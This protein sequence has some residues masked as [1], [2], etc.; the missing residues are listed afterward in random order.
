M[1]L[2]TTRQEATAHLVQNHARKLKLIEDLLCVI[3]AC[4]DAYE[5]VSDSSAYARICG[6]TLLKG[7]NLGLGALSLSLDGLAQEAGALIRPFIEYVELLTYFR[8]FPEMVERALDGD[9]PKA[10][11]RARAID[12][13]YHGFRAHLNEHASHSSYSSFSLGHL[14]D[15]R[16]LKFKK[17]QTFTP[18][19]LERNV[20]DIT[21]QMYFLLR[22]AVLS[23][24]LTQH[25]DFERI[26][27]VA[28]ELKPHLI[29]IFDL[30]FVT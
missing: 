1:Q 7:K 19:V 17:Q 24:E 11:Q 9:L 12:S 2:W 13:F 16:S 23:L 3:D 8:K 15:G 22:E 20:R 27:T 26:A 25:S 21:V 6:L 18:H 14:I 29:D 4:V 30:E 10:G 28:D 5:Q